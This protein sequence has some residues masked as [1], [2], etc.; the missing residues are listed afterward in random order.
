VLRLITICPRVVIHAKC[1]HS[2]TPCSSLQRLDTEKKV[3]AQ[4]I[5]IKRTQAHCTIFRTEKEK[6]RDRERERSQTQKH[7]EKT[8]KKKKER[9]AKLL[10]IKEYISLCLS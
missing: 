3:R 2:P 1:Y 9:E 4:G 5:K 7:A 6:E 10:K 8:K